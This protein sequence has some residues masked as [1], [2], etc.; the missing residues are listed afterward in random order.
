MSDIKKRILSSI[1]FSVICVLVNFIYAKYSHNVSS[2]YM[3]YMFVIPLLG[4]L[5][6]FISRNNEYQNL[7]AS[8]VLTIV[9]S[10]FLGGIVEIAG[11]TSIF[12]YILL[13]IGILLFLLS[14]FCIKPIEKS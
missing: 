11:T 12:I 9:L 6:S 4:L 13:A 2:I 8:S 14:L 1:I 10:S 3:T 5:I 7:L